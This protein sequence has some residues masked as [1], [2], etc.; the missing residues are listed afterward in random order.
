MQNSSNSMNSHGF[1]TIGLAGVLKNVRRIRTDCAESE[2]F[3][4]D[5]KSGELVFLGSDF[6]S[7]RTFGRDLAILRAPLG[8]RHPNIG[9]L[10]ISGGSPGPEDRPACAA[11][12]R[13]SLGPA[14]LVHADSPLLHQTPGG[15][16]AVGGKLPVTVVA[17]A[18]IRF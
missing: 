7:S 15:I 3:W 13:H 2:H 18:T 4:W 17:R 5:R 6:S 1:L 8:G 12:G 9:R 10:L 16:G 14:P 11:T